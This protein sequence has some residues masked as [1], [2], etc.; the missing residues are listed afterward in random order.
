MPGLPGL[1][2][3][4]PMTP[5]DALDLDHLPEHLIV[6]GGVEVARGIGHHGRKRVGK[7]V[8]IGAVLPLMQ[9]LRSFRIDPGKVSEKGD[10]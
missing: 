5:V 8:L 4:Q 9:R 10:Y 1:A 2:A 7:A 3:G 6:L